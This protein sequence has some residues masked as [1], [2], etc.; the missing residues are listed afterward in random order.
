MM[1]SSVWLLRGYAGLSAAYG[2][3][4][5][6]AP[7]SACSRLIKAMNESGKFTLHFGNIT[8][9]GYGALLLAIAEKGDNQ[10]MV[11]AGRISMIMECFHVLNVFL[12]K[13]NFT[14]SAIKEVGIC[15]GGIIA[16][17]GYHFFLSNN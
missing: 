14:D 12:H 5:L 8:M 7:D 13:S 15:S 16:L 6:V 4:I 3:Q 11:M 10:M 17:F 2:V 1:L 9:L